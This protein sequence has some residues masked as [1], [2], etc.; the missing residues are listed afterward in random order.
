MCLCVSV[1]PAGV[2]QLHQ[3]DPEPTRIK[4]EPE[5]QGTGQD[6]DAA[7]NRFPFTVVTV[8]S[9]DEE[10]EPQ[11]SQL[12]QRQ[13]EEKLPG[14]SS[15]TQI[16]TVTNG[17]DCGGS[18]PARNRDP[19]SYSQ[20]NTDEKTLD[21]SPVLY[22]CSFC[23]HVILCIQLVYYY[24]YMFSMVQNHRHGNYVMCVTMHSENNYILCI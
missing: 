7:I 12:C 13:T 11:T 20:P 3:K 22:S 8:K 15:T 5:E 18:D 1:F 4:E 16:K 24:L 9:E 21:S 14:R 10:V 17:E 19:G 6:G 2:Q 23:G